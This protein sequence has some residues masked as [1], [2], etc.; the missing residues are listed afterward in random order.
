[1]ER[2]VINK[3]V[4]LFIN[5]VMCITPGNCSRLL[6]HVHRRT[7]INMPHNFGILELKP[8]LKC[9][10]PTN[11]YVTLVQRSKLRLQLNLLH[12]FIPWRS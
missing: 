4:W 12:L 6:P 2:A 9:A 10:L 8:D 11:V 5:I 7:Y 3:I 1:M